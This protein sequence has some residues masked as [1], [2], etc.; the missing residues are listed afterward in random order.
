M[1]D[2][3]LIQNN[4]LMRTFKNV[5]RKNKNTRKEKKEAWNAIIVNVKFKKNS[6]LHAKNVRKASAFHV[7]NKFVEIK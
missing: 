1:E 5:E 7:Y 4:N 2:K 6:Y 3:Q